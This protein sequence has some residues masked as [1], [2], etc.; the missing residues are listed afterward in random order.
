MFVAD[1][2]SAPILARETERRI[3]IGITVMPAAPTSA[4]VPA[5]HFEPEVSGHILDRYPVPDES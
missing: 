5:E 4:A 1:E 3:R 2:T